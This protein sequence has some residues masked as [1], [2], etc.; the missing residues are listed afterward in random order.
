MP[1]S[2][3]PTCNFKL[4]RI[5]YSGGR[6]PAGVLG[7]EFGVTPQK[8]YHS[9]RLGLNSRNHPVTKS[10]YDHTH[11]AADEM[12]QYTYSK[13]LHQ[14]CELGKLRQLSHS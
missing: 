14:L 4:G 11:H 6:K 12:G 1:N 2:V 3:L 13:S 7:G 9:V 10:K 5:G 8:R